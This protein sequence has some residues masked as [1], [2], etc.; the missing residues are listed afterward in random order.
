MYSVRAAKA[1]GNSSDITDVKKTDLVFGW[2]ILG[3][4]VFLSIRKSDTRQI[5][6]IFL[7]SMF[8]LYLQGTQI[9]SDDG[10]F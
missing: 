7:N 5:N 4:S 1:A 6:N 2:L 9:K 8:R 10:C 3:L